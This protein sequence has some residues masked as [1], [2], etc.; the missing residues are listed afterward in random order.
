MADT[1]QTTMSETG[2][3]NQNILHSHY[4]FKGDSQLCWYLKEKMPVMLRFYTLFEVLTI[5]KGIIR[6]ERMFDMRNPA[7]I[8]CDQ[9]LEK[10]LGMKALHV[11]QIRELVYKQLTVIPSEY[12][13]E[14]RQLRA[15]SQITDQPPS[16][17][18]VNTRNE[19]INTAI[20]SASP[21]AA[22]VEPDIYKDE[23]S[24]FAMKP[25]FRQVLSILP[26]FNTNQT[27]F[28]FAEATALLS[29][30]ILLKK[31][32]IFDPIKHKISYREKRSSRRSL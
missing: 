26:D 24:K 16:T 31:E 10:A 18:F 3:V 8:L 7:I 29:K 6:D 27:L 2:E 11:S 9:D 25:L 21:I 5:L 14:I 28:T 4:A 17:P 30:Y 20:S 32:S 19:P 23:N 15:I 12:K 22:K 1:V 13:T